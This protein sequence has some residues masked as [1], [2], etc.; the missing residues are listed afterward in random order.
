MS[1]S[2]LEVRDIEPINAT[3]ITITGVG[4]DEVFINF[5][6]NGVQQFAVGDWDESLG[7]VVTIPLAQPIPVDHLFIQCENES[8]DCGQFHVYLVGQ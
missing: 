8:D 3:L 2:G 1:A 5:L 7:P 6:S 4:D